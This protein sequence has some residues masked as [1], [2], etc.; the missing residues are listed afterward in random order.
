LLVEWASHD[1]RYTIFIPPNPDSSEWLLN[2]ESATGGFYAVWE[3]RG[4]KV[5]YS[6]FGVYEASYIV[7]ISS[8]IA[9]AVVCLI[10]WKKEF[11]WRKTGEIIKR[12]F[13]FGRSS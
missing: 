6:R 13:R 8:A 2:G 7:S 3:S 5:G 11:L 1:K 4:G 9:I 12:L 10:L